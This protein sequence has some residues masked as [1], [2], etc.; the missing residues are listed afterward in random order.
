MKGCEVII[1]GGGNCEIAGKLTQEMAYVHQIKSKHLKVYAKT[2]LL[3]KSCIG[4]FKRL[5]PCFLNVPLVG[6]GGIEEYT[7]KGDEEGI[8]KKE[9]VLGESSDPVKME[10]YLKKVLKDCEEKEIYFVVIGQ[11]CEQ[12]LLIDFVGEE[13]SILTYEDFYTILKRVSKTRKVYFHL[14]LDIPIW[15]AIE[16]P[17]QIAQ[18]TSV[19]SLFI[20]ERTHPLEIFP[21]AQWLEQTKGTNQHPLKLLQHQYKG[22]TIITHSL[23]WAFCKKQ[24]LAY[25]EDPCH[26]TWQAFYSYYQYLVRHNG[27]KS[28]GY[29]KT[30]RKETDNLGQD[31]LTPEKL[32]D[33]I[34]GI[35]GE[36]VDE[37][38]IK[39]I[40]KDMKK[41]V[42][43]YKL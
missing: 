30:F 29:I 20:F 21:V 19:S 10:N 11:S 32:K 2:Y 22:Y 6:Q 33:Y 36:K 8:K 27:K 3:E 5:S 25:K 4:L 39:E 42:S 12:G 28:S 7:Y 38:C 35:Y 26:K 40:I 15:D 13:P 1:Y 23:W 41:C 17:Y 9:L 24:W 14:I 37:E 31:I 16:L 34:Q 18:I 43:Y